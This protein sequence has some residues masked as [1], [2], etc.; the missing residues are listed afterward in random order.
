MRTIRDWYQQLPD[1]IRITALHN[2]LTMNGEQR[3]DQV[4]TSLYDALNHGFNWGRTSQG[5]TFWRAIADD[6]LRNIPIELSRYRG[7]NMN[8]ARPAEPRVRAIRPE[9]VLINTEDFFDMPLPS[10]KIKIPTTIEEWIAMLKPH[11]FKKAQA[12]PRYKDVAPTSKCSSWQS[13][14]SHYIDFRKSSEGEVF[15]NYVANHGKEYVK[16]EFRG[17]VNR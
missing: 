16:Q 7:L 12:A 4:E 9:D 5:D 6:A 17:Y 15:W 8:E 11:Y 14:I 2:V 3:L 1:G 10:G 13:A